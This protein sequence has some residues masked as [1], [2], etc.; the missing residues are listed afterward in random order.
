LC[1]YRNAGT[2]DKAI[3]KMRRAAWV[4]RLSSEAQVA[5]ARAA[6]RTL[7]IRGFTVKRSRIERLNIA[8]LEVGRLQAREL[9]STQQQ[10]PSAPERI[11]VF[12]KRGVEP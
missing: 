2:E 6:I 5:F 10:R 3:K 9:V 4:E 11:Q 7:A 1:N 12:T 8:E